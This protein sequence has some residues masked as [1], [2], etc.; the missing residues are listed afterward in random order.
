MPYGSPGIFVE[1]LASE[2]LEQNIATPSVY[3]VCSMNILL[4]NYE[5]P[6]I[7]GGAATATAAI[8]GHLT[9]LGHSVTVLTSRFGDLKGTVREGDVRVVRCPAIRKHPDRSGILEMFSFL[10][11]AGLMLVSVI[12]THR[13]EASIVFFSFPCGPLGLWGLKRENV[14][15]VIS[16][17][18]GDVPGNEASLAPLHRLLTPL[19]RLVFRRSVAVVANSPGLKEMSERSDPCRVQV[20]PNG[21]DT[22]YFCPIE[23]RD[24]TAHRPVAFLFVGRFQTA[25]N[26]FYLFDQVA[27]LKHSGVGA[28]VLHLVGDGPQNNDLRSHAKRMGIED[29]L[30]WHGWVDKGRLREI[31]RSV[32]CLVNPSL[33]EGMPNV[34]LEAMACG[35][36][37]IASRVPGNDT[38]VRPGE[39]GWLFDLGKPDAFRKALRE[40]VENRERASQMGQKGRAWVLKDFSW[41]HVAQAYVDLFSGLARG[42]P[43][44]KRPGLAADQ[45]PA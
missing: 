6:P 11:S 3:P 23:N 10:V 4:I 35:L 17:R 31:Y 9:S 21:V 36:P 1:H 38:V 40:M 20:I 18:G 43:Q 42:T 37:V 39:T 41:R 24:E 2:F 27:S 32:D 25:K 19:R 34:V 5:Y 30:V 22:D 28:F 12:R 29:C 26:L 33:C 16:L 13:I 7:G 45:L 8:A 44:E 15:Y 14:P